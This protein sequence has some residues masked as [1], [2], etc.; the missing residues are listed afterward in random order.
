VS[1]VLKHAEPPEGGP[2]RVG[3]VIASRRGRVRRSP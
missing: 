1:I 3:E 2:T